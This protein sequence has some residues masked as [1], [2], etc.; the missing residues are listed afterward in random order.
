MV[1]V[2]FINGGEANNV[3]PETVKFGGTYRSLNTEGLSYIKERI[4]EV[5]P[6]LSF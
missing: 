2:G 3:I 1:S 6:E 4:K 5:N